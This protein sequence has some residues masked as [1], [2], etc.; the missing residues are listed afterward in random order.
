MEMGDRI[1][2]ARMVKGLSQVRLADLAGIHRNTLRN[3]EKGVTTPRTVFL[4]SLEEVL[5]TKL[6]TRGD[7]H[8]RRIAQCK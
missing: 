3:Y 6:K 8:E 2:R 4:E 5:Q 7:M 1:K